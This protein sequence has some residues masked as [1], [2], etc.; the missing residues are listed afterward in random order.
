[1]KSSA[2]TKTTADSISREAPPAAPAPASQPIVQSAVPVD[3]ARPPNPVFTEMS[4]AAL[5]AVRAQ[6]THKVKRLDCELELV[7]TNTGCYGSNSYRDQLI[8]GA[9]WSKGQQH[10]KGGQYRVFDG[11]LDRG[12]QICFGDPDCQFLWI[13]AKDKTGGGEGSRLLPSCKQM[14]L[15]GYDLYK[16]S[17]RATRAKC[18]GIGDCLGPTKY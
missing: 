7:A 12:M 14:T 3:V 2:Y 8:E 18:V 1:M 4:G 6:L 15:E 10:D 16:K 17:C 11:G 5:D 13:A 9:T